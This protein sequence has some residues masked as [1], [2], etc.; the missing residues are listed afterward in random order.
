MTATELL[1]IVSTGE[2]SK[3]QFKEEMPHRDGIAQEIVAM[4]NS[5]EGNIFLAFPHQAIYT[6]Q[7][8]KDHQPR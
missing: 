8:G 1:D 7:S 4:S 3:V 5:V 6:R 2:T